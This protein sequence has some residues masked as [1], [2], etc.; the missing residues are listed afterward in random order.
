MKTVVMILLAVTAL[1]GCSYLPVPGSGGM[2]ELKP[3]R[4]LAEGKP[5]G[6]DDGLLFENELLSKQLDALVLQGGELCYPAT[7]ALAR[8]RENRITRALHGGLEND[9]RTDLVEQQQL[10]AQV[11]RRLYRDKGSADCQ[12]T[13]NNSDSVKPSGKP[14]SA[15]E[16]VAADDINERLKRL[17]SM[18][19]DFIREIKV[20]PSTSFIRPAGSPGSGNDQPLLSGNNSKGV[21][22]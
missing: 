22:K 16:M 3:V 11:E 5:Y 7:I 9:A 20:T 10:L 12:L 21:S 8:Q 17:T 6:P 4:S 19:Y 14:S 13:D 1:S 15:S 18:Q 2:A